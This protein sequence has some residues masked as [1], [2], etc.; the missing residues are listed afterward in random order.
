MEKALLATLWRPPI[1]SCCRLTSVEHPV[2]T[3]LAAYTKAAD[4]YLSESARPGPKVLEHLRRFA[5][6]VG[7][8]PALEIGSG[9]GWD[10]EQ[11]ESLGCRVERTDAT[12]SFVDRLQQRGHA[13]RLLDVRHD[14]LGGPYAGVLANAVLL[15]LPRD[16]FNPVIRRIRAALHQ[17]GTFGLTLR[18]GD[19]D[20][21]SMHKLEL[22]RYFTFWREHQLLRVLKD[23]SF[24]AEYVERYTSS[25]NG[26][27]WLL[28]IARAV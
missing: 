13:A 14:E 18:E 24:Q 20:A 11:L 28:V 4:R 16:E 9:P 6:R 23:S 2:D 26:D 1:R 22:P 10:A 7:A 17:D 27:E 3:T 25:S 8:G 5:V 19:G 15:H 12:A 21:W